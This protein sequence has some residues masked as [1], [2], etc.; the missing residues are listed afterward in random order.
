LNLMARKRRL[1]HR[2]CWRM[3]CRK[4]AADHGMMKQ[5]L[6]LGV[7]LALVCVASCAAQD[8]GYW[9]QASSSAKAITGDIVISGKAVTLDYLAFPLVPVR[10]LKAAEVG[11]VFDA[12]VNIGPTGA[13]YRVN[14]PANRLLL[15]H[16]TLC[17]GDDATWMA[18]YVSGRYLQVAFFSGDNPP[19]FTF[20]AIS[21][22]TALCG[23]FIYAR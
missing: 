13:L 10:A 12:D 18:T 7:L 19:V 5:K 3:L 15:H 11:A 14:I 1:P 2:R 16:N 23:T 8:Q 9:R 6:I 4:G 20:D 17:S 21:H 22:S